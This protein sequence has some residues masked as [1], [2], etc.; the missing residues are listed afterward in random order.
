MSSKIK[1]KCAGCGQDAWKWPRDIRRGFS[2]LYCSH[3]CRKSRVTLICRVCQKPFEVIKAVAHR[4]ST[5]SKECADKWRSIQFTKNP[6][7]PRLKFERSC[8]VCDNSFMTKPSDNKCFFWIIDVSS[9]GIEFLV[10]GSAESSFKRSSWI[11]NHLINVDNIHCEI[12]I[13]TL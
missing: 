9:Y 4:R 13:G 3:D 8:L 11:S 2:R 5:C 6:P 1:V 10:C 12:I 7:S